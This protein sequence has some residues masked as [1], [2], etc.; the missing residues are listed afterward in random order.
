MAAGVNVSAGQDCIKDP[1]YPFGTGQMLEVAHLLVHADHLSLPDQLEAVMDC[2][3]VNP[4]RSMQLSDY[5]TVPG[6]RADLVILPVE[7]VHEAIRRRPRP[8]AVIKNGYR[9]VPKD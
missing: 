5:G 1:F 9:L 4:A 8:I 3:T 7:S 2:I 6:C